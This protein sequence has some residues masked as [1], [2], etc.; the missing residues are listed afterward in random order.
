MI[1]LYSRCSTHEQATTG[2]SMPGQRAALDGFSASR[3]FPDAQHFADPAVSGTIPIAERPEG[4]RLVRAIEDGTVTG[5]VVCRLDRA[6]RNVIDCLTSVQRWDEHGVTLYIQNLGGMSVDTSSALGKFMLTLMGALAAMERDLTAERV[7]FTLQHLK[8]CG[9]RLGPL[10]LGLK[11]AADE[12]TDAEGRRVIETDLDGL[13]T[14]ERALA[15]RKS[16]MG[17]QEVSD[18][19]NAAGRTA[20]GGGAWSRGSVYKMLQREAAKT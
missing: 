8:A 16:G 2:L 17:W 1:A 11:Y 10:P 6:W 15:L 3:A 12:A 5:V 4:G 19:L 18:A 9:V 7:S 20:K 13:A 14:V